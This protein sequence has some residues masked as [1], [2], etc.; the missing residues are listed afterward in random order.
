M[1]IKQRLHIAFYGSNG[2]G[3][4]LMLQ[5]SISALIVLNVFA[6]L[7]ETEDQ[8]GV[9]YRTAFSAF[10][11]FSVTIF[12]VEYLARIWVSNLSPRYMPPVGNRLSYMLSPMALIDLLAIAPSL[13]SI[14]GVD[15]RVVRLVRLM[16]L[17]KLTRYSAAMSALA[18]AIRAGKD[19]LVL[20]VFIMGIL[21]LFSG[22]LIYFAEH[23]AQPEEF[24]SIPASLWWAV[25][26]LTTIGYGDVYPVTIA[27]K[28]IA[29]VSAIFGIGMIA[30]PGG[31]IANGLIQNAKAKSKNVCPHCGKAN[32]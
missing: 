10:E 7:L 5:F 30:L 1:S 12:T 8:L 20:T 15:L 27:G 13:L 16:R 14:A 26:T 22:T 23:N 3:A 11:W 21:L 19:E 9:A 29:G 4:S 28:V 18:A 17:F 32:N 24:S 6:V 2:T 25:V 31:I